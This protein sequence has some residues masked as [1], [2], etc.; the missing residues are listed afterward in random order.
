MT[1]VWVRR[2]FRSEDAG[3]LGSV[4]TVVW[5]AKVLGPAKVSPR[6]H[7]RFGFCND[8]GL[9]PTGVLPRRRWRFGSGSLLDHTIR[10]QGL[11]AE[12]AV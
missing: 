9:S 11:A 12:T 4:T 10:S 6:R 5:V 8:G 2:R 7:R 1:V 3:G